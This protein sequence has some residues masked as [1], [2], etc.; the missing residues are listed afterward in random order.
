MQWV[1]VICSNNDINIVQCWMTH[2]LIELFIINP[3]C[4]IS[5]THVSAPPSPH[6]RHHVALGSQWKAYC[7]ILETC[8]WVY[9]NATVFLCFYNKVFIVVVIAAYY[10]Q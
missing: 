5:D 2:W 8:K 1:S 3:K 4:V 7:L 6:S 10:V 9:S